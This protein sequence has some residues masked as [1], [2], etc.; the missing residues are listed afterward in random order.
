MLFFIFG[1]SLVT[2]VTDHMAE[3]GAFDDTRNEKLV[4]YFGFLGRATLSLYMSMS[5]GNDWVVYYEAL[6]LLPDQYRFFFL[7]FISVAIFGVVNIV[8]G[9]FVESAMANSTKDR[10]VMIHEELESKKSY[11][12]AMRQFFEEADEDGT[13]TMGFDEF[14]KK[15]DDDIV[16]A[17][18]NAHQLDV[19]DASE[20]FTLLDFDQSGEIEIEEFLDGCYKLQGQSR[21]LDMKIT[22]MEVKWLREAVAHIT[23]LLTS[24]LAAEAAG[25][26]LRRRSSRGSRRSSR[27]L[28]QSQWPKKNSEEANGLHAKKKEANVLSHV[29]GEA[30]IVD[31]SQPCYIEEFDTASIHQDQDE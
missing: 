6:G 14:K 5:S 10:E 15:L 30:Q 20:L 1:I 31:Y 8:T 25:Q 21:A 11:Q 23:E 28:E 9:V 22:Q 16:I 3:A 7:T 27:Q 13:G 26:S 12:E 29:S 24:S 2:G 18:L 17:Y 19:S 4:E